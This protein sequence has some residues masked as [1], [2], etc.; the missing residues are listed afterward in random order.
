M[1]GR[2]KGGRTLVARLD[3]VCRTTG[4]TE[5]ASG[6]TAT[7]AMVR[8]TTIGPPGDRAAT[9]T[10]TIARF[11]L[12]PAGR[13]SWI[14]ATTIDARRATRIVRGRAVPKG[15]AAT[16]GDVKTDPATTARVST[17][18]VATK[19]RETTGVT[20]AAMKTGATATGRATMGPIGRG[21]HPFNPTRSMTSLRLPP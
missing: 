17:V 2:T 11:R 1:R 9:F 19:V 8:A 7:I 20:A 15:P 6:A 5:K 12:R 21:S 13:R 16:S 18:A 4:I 3:P 10:P 14:V